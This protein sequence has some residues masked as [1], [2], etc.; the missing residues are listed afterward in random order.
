MGNM[1]LIR[2]LAG[3]GIAY[4]LLII[5]TIGYSQ[6]ECTH[7]DDWIA[8]MSSNTELADAF[9][10]SPGIEDAWLLG[11]VKGNDI[12]DNLSSLK[13]LG[14]DLVDKDGLKNYLSETSGGIDNWMVL[15]RGNASLKSIDNIRAL[16]AFKIAN[17][18]ITDDAIESALYS[19]KSS[20][21]QPFVDGLKKVSDNDLM[22]LVNKRL[23]SVDEVRDAVNNLRDFRKSNPSVPGEKNIAY[24]DGTIN[25]Q[26]TSEFTSNPKWISGDDTPLEKPSLWEASEATDASGSTYKRPFDSEYKM[27]NDLARELEPNAILGQKYFSHSGEIKIVSEIG[28]CTSCA[29][30]IS[31]FSTMFPNLKIVLI[32]GIK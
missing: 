2:R 12:V 3:Q 29:G 27:L 16:D 28:Y 22:P 30:I 25:G 1:N 23:A 15:S 14:Q 9:R 21:R 26:S 4:L 8:A 24:L 7:G 20:R 13:K 5:S 10:A 11:F 17:P 18:G 32:D 6:I 19:L 31:D